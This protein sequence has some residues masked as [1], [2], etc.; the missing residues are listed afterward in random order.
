MLVLL[1]GAV[2]AYQ[3]IRLNHLED[4]LAANEKV[5]VETQNRD[6][7]RLDGLDG[8]AAEIEKQLGNAFNPE[9][10]SAAALP[11]VFRV[12]AGNVAARRSRSA[13]RP[14]AAAPTCSPTGTSSRSS[15]TAAAAR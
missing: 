4:R 2:A 12:T 6:N 11:S 15:T 9:A 3:T 14:A 13:S 7:T 10:I 1:L 8:R 5:L